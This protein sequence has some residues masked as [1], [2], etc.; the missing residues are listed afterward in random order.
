MG[1]FVVE[2]FDQRIG[3]VRSIIRTVIKF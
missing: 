2:D 1:I 3:I